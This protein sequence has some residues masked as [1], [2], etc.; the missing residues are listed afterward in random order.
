VEATLLPWSSRKHFWLIFAP[1]R[2]KL[3]ATITLS[4]ALRVALR[5]D[6]IIAISVDS[7][8]RRFSLEEF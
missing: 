5:R 3:L 2:G 1:L 6:P 4:E 7:D 8:K